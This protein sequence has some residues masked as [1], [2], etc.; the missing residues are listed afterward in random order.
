MDLAGKKIAFLGDSITEGCGTSS[1]EHTFW[2]VLGQKT[3][4]QVFGYGIGGTRI[5]P[6][7]VPS[8]PRA[9]QDFISRVDG[10]IP[11]ADVVVVFGGTNDFGH[12]DAPFGTRG[13]QTSETFCGALHVLFTKLYER[14]PAAQ[15]VVMTPTHR[16]SETDSVMNEFGVRR[17]GNLR[18]YVQ[19]IRDAAEDFA[20]PVLDLFRV[21]GIQPSVPALREA[22]M[23]D[24]LHPN[25]AGHAKIADKLIGFLQTL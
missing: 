6:Q 8:D 15:L 14:Y 20:V 16:L 17:S 22:Y 13:D 2:N 1:L 19:A 21:S 4:A 23:P 11:D 12:G 5:A 18:A 25:D 9:D 7:R 3:G 10:M 24:G